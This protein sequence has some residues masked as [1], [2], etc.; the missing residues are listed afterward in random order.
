[1][2]TTKQGG[3]FIHSFQIQTSAQFKSPNRVS[4]TTFSRPFLFDSFRPNLFP[5]PP[6]PQITGSICSLIGNVKDVLP[7]A[8]DLLG[9]FKGLIVDPNPE[10]RANA[11]KALGQLY[12]GLGESN[13]EGLVQWLIELLKSDT[14]SVERSG[15]A[16]GLAEVLAASG[17]AGVRMRSITP[18]RYRN[19]C[20]HHS[21]DE[22][23]SWPPNN[24]GIF[25]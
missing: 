8:P 15:A 22:G 12:K 13:F 14:T 7:Y 19:I 20:S 16:Q 21:F 6:L 1:V 3:K 18:N 2:A 10:V 17:T 4:A 11:A 9:D 25:V 5:P 24:C 23:K